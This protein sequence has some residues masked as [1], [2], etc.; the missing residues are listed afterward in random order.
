MGVAFKHFQCTGL[1]ISWMAGKA[2]SCELVWVS[3]RGATSTAWG[4]DS[5]ACAFQLAGSAGTEEAIAGRAHGKP[6]PKLQ[7][8]R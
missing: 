4:K 1:W 5:T 2:D 3:H 6:L 7:L 8:H